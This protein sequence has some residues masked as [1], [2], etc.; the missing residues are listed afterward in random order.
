MA[1][2]VKHLVEHCPTCG[3][4]CRVRALLPPNWVIVDESENVVA[5]GFQDEATA[6]SH[7]SFYNNGHRNAPRTR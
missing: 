1:W 2:A 3:G 5:S 6:L 4:P 7:L